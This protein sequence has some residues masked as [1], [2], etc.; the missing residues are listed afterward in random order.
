M[1]KFMELSKKLQSLA[2]EHG[3]EDFRDAVVQACFDASI[4]TLDFNSE[5]LSKRYAALGRVVNAH[6]LSEQEEGTKP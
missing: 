3:Y 1:S 5:V 6:A 4:D 2:H